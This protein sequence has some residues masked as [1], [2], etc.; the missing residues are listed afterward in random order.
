MSIA[1]CLFFL[2]FSLLFTQMDY[3]AMFT[4]IMCSLWLGAAGPIMIGGLYTRFGTTFGAWCALFF[5]SGSSLLGLICQR[6]WADIIYP[7]L[8]RGGYVDAVG[9]AMTVVS[10]PLNPYVVW[11]MDPIK[12]PI[13][14]IEIY[15]MAM[16][17]GLAGYLIGSLLTQKEGFNLDRLLHRGKYH[18]D[19]EVVSDGLKVPLRTRLYSMLIGITPEYTKGDKIIAWSVFLWSIVYGFGI[20]FCGVLLWNAVSPWP[21]QNWGVYFFITTI[22]TSLVVGTVSTIWFMT[23]G[24]IDMRAMF[25]DLRAR[26]ANPLDDG[27]VVGHVSLADQK[28]FEEIEHQKE[29]PKP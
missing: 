3:I 16:V 1:V 23:G 24:I 8:E 11:T 7:W 22:C 26:I 14:S 12:F 17:L 20:M 2:I 25:R 5:G 15:F 4:S 13:N 9:N 27:R 10:K 29:E 18:P 21:S 19:G 6:N 28:H